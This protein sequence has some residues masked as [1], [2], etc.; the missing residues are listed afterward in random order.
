MREISVIS[1]TKDDSIFT[2]AEG[3]E[4]AYTLRDSIQQSCDASRSQECFAALPSFEVC[5][6][7]FQP[8]WHA[9]TS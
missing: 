7:V 8:R 1:V 6:C 5:M 4:H 9:L 3:E 2:S